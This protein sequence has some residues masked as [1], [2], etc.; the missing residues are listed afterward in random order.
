[1]LIVVNFRKKR[2]V[3]KAPHA[4]YLPSVDFRDPQIRRPQTFE[5][6][7]AKFRSIRTWGGQVGQA[8]STAPN[9]IP[10]TKNNIVVSNLELPTR[11]PNFGDRRKIIG[12]M[13]DFQKP[14]N[15]GVHERNYFIGR[16]WCFTFAASN[17]GDSLT[18]LGGLLDG[19]LVLLKRSEVVVS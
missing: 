11:F 5:L 4:C 2:H 13:N 18:V 1:M 7:P 17:L 8:I 10:K 3:K 6:H 15:F 16:Q 19:Q 9:F 12:P 14:P